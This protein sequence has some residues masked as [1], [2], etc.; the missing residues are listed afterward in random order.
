[1]INIEELSI[2]E[3]NMTCKHS[4]NDPNCGS[5]RP[6]EPK[7]P[8]SSNYEVVDIIEN[9]G[10]L[11]LKAKYPNCDSCAFEGTKIM[12]FEKVSLLKAFKWKTIDPHFR[13]P[14]RNT[15]LAEREAPSPVA[16]FPGNDIGWT[17][18]QK[19]VKMLLTPVKEEQRTDW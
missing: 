6:S 15:Y 11:I 9:S 3:Q 16:R 4:A 8:D 18:A 13:D 5:Y 19:F 17:N 12:V 1:M 14:N 10:Y 2:K 7:T